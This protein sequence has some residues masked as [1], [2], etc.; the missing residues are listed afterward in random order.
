MKVF[1]ATYNQYDNYGSR[2]QNFALCQV[3][4]A[5]G[6]QPMTLE[7]CSSKD[8]I[9]RYVKDI[10]ALL[11]VICDKQRLWIND[12]KKRI[13]FSDFNKR[14]NLQTMNYDD[15]YNLDFANAIAIAGS[16][17]IWSPIHIAKKRREA[18]LYFLRFAPQE[19]RFAYAPS[20]GMKV[21]PDTLMEMYR[22]YITEFQTLSVRENIGQK[23]IKDMTDLEVP[24]LPD[25]TFLLSKNEW[26]LAIYASQ[27]N[28][29]ASQ[30]IL[31]YFLSEQN[32]CLWNCIKRY[33]ERKKLKIICVS[34]NKYHKEDIRPAPDQFINLINNAEAVFTDSFHGAVFSTIMQTPFVVF[35]RS[36]VDQISR[37]DTLLKKYKLTVAF[38]EAQEPNCDFDMIF[39][40]ENFVQV[41]KIVAEERQKGTAYL[42]KIIQS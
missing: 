3:L 36:D 21:I 30:Y 37:I 1:I 32:K 2:L 19:K 29:S 25:P 12:K 13:I 41:E 42:K 4:N 27:M 23:I 33:A 10:F 24:V 6:T 20:F 39:E 40:K 14:L 35:R 11:P 38:L 9:I 8:R 5:L 34:G 22:K 28:I 26:M 15:L 7:I 18:E 31:T 16:D 17:Q